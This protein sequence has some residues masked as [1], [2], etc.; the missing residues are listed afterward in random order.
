MRTKTLLSSNTYMPYLKEA[1][2]A[3]LSR[4]SL[5]QRLVYGNKHVICK[6]GAYLVRDNE[7]EATVEAIPIRQNEE[8]VDVEDRVKVLKGLVNRILAECRAG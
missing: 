4:G 7:T 3:H 8:G 1:D 2:E 6:N 5:G